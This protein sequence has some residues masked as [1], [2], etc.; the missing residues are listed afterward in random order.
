MKISGANQGIVF[1]EAKIMNPGRSNLENIRITDA[2][3]VG[4]YLS[5]TM[6]VPYVRNVVVSGSSERFRTQGIAFK[7]AQ[8]DDL[9]MSDCIARDAGIGYQF[10][11]VDTPSNYDTTRSTWGSLYN[12][13]AENVRVGI[14]VI[15]EKPE[16]MMQPVTFNGGKILASEI[17]VWITQCRMQLTLRNTVITGGTNAAL[18][19]GGESVIFSGCT[20][21]S[22]AGEGMVLRGTKNAVI[23]QSKIE[24]ETIGG[25]VDNYTA[26]GIVVTDNTISAPVKVDNKM[27]GGT[28]I[29]GNR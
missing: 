26:G 20:L 7:M 14:K 22:S 11:D 6:D 8:N 27:S 5:G 2:G 25:V 19:E 24:A 15:T 23:H 17:G 10:E 18:M 21:T 12:C 3:N 28:V 13:S 1:G 4:V 16:I 29:A 9:R